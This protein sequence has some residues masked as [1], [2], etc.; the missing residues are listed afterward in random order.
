MM[1]Y[2]VDSWANVRFT[3]NDGIREA[4]KR[5]NAQPF[6][7]AY[8]ELLIPLQQCGDSFKLVEK[9]ARYADACVFLVVDF[10]A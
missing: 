6:A 5:I 2:R 9:C 1:R 3:V 8:A 4:A 10:Y 7:D